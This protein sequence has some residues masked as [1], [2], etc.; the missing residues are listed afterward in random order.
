MIERKVGHGV[1][2]VSERLV[3]LVGWLDG[4]VM[5]TYVRS[6]AS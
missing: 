6:L 1:L 2:S 4:W 3:D 5:K